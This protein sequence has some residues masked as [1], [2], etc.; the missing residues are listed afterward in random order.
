MPGIGPGHIQHPGQ[1]IETPGQCHFN[2]GIGF[3]DFHQKPG[4][5][6]H[7][8]DVPQSRSP[9]GCQCRPKPAVHIPSR[10]FSCS[11]LR[12]KPVSLFNADTEVLSGPAGPVAP[13]LPP[14]GIDA[15]SGHAAY[16][17]CSPADFNYGNGKYFLQQGFTVLSPDSVPAEPPIRSFPDQAAGRPVCMPAGRNHAFAG[18]SIIPGACLPAVSPQTEQKYAQTDVS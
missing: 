13:G 11:A 4:E 8:H 10:V 3:P 5:T 14:A 1:G 17:G 18:L 2:A 12:A 7:G 16:L 6:V 9:H 15:V